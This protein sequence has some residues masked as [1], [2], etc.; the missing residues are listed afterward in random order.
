M[1]LFY[2]EIEIKDKLHISNIQKDL[3]KPFLIHQR[4]THIWNIPGLV[5]DRNRCDPFTKEM[6]VAQMSCGH[7]IGPKRMYSKIR[8]LIDTKKDEIR[9]DY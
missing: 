9:C 5:T 3:G 8:N 1:S 7:W 2:G 4:K 6:G